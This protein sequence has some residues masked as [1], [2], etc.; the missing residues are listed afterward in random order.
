MRWTEV[1]INTVVLLNVTGGAALANE[2]VLAAVHS[3]ADDVT[4]QNDEQQS[5]ASDVAKYLNAMCIWTL[6]IWKKSIWSEAFKYCEVSWHIVSVFGLSVCLSHDNFRKPWC[7]KFIFAHRV[8]LH[9]IR[10]KFVHEGHRVKVT[11]TNNV[12][13]PCSCMKCKVRSAI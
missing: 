5:V 9:G 10:I 3:V 4:Q 11:G 13:N 1:V 7:R 12:E 2:L 6:N 8:H